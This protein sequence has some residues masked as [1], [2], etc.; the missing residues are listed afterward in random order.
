MTEYG[1]LLLCAKEDCMNKNVKFV[2]VTLR[3]GHQSLAATRMT[4]DQALRALKMIDDAGF[5]ALELWGGATLDSCIRFLGEDPWERLEKFQ[6]VLG[7]S[8]KIRALLRGQNLFGYQPSSDDLVISF[9]KEAVQ[10][11]VGIMRIFDALNDVRNLQTSILTTKAY[12]GVA[13][14]ALS[15]TT[16]PIHTT[17]YFLDFALKLQ[18]WGVDQIAV[19]DMAGL[20]HPTEALDLF[21]KLKKQT[22]LPIVMHSHTTTG[23]ATL[24][25]IIAMHE[26][27][28]YIDTAIT[29]FAG[30]TSHPPIEVV[31]V[32]AEEMGIDHG[33]DKELILQAQAELFKVYEELGDII[34]DRNKTHKP[35]SYGDVDRK[36]VHEIL[37]LVAKSNKESI[38][39]AIPLMRD[40]LMSLNYPKFDDKI[41]EAQVPGGMLSNLYNQ[42]KAMDQ[43]DRMDDIME[44]IPR[45]RSDAGYVPLVTP[46]SQIVGS[47]AAFNVISGERYQM[48]SNEFKM[49]LK[50]EFGRTPGPTNPEVMQKVL[51]SGE[52]PLKYRAASYLPPVLEDEYNLPFVKTHK[53]LLLHL[54]FKQSADTFLKQRYGVSA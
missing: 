4:T 51:Q 13:E 11:G 32:F 49:I 33:L 38:E 30:G 53:D 27:I 24:N 29:P 26:G 1:P 3:D 15:Y 16:S 9:V 5:A 54:L 21:K 34:A 40:L 18:D 37:E 43:L 50:G 25:A 20:L 17:D 41:F 47:Q 39:K 31:I 14:G 8:K 19:K 36:K 7:S 52:E 44:E 45:V 42:L 35:V 28:D 23:V 46:T 12:G 6:E 48:V 22:D 10:S 2:D